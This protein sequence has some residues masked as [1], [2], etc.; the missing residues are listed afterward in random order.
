[1]FEGLLAPFRRQYAVGARCS[2]C[3]F[4]DF[5]Y[6][7]KGTPFSDK[8]KCPHCEAAYVTQ[9]WVDPLATRVADAIVYRRRAV[10]LCDGV[11]TEARSAPMKK[12]TVPPE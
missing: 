3:G 5:V 6:L 7:P 12:P 8:V 11:R 1:M 10:R 4:F 9:T 2:N